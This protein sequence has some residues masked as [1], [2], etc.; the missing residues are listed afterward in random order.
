MQLSIE[1]SGHLSIRRV[2]QSGGSWLETFPRFKVEYRPW[3][4]IWVFQIVLRQVMFPNCFFKRYGFG[5]L[6]RYGI[7]R[8]CMEIEYSSELY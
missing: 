1:G 6:L 7:V 3:I 4:P 2:V 8:Q 5:K